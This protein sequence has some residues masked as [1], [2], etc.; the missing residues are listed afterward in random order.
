MQPLPA[1]GLPKDQIVEG[2]VQVRVSSAGLTTL[3]EFAGEIIRTLLGEGVCLPRTTGTFSILGIQTT[4]RACEERNQCGGGRQG[5]RITASVGTTALHAPSA[6][7]LRL[8]AQNVTGHAATTVRAAVN[9]GIFGTLNLSCAVNLQVK[10]LDIEADVNIGTHADTGGI[11]V[12]LADL[13]TIN[14]DVD[15]GGCLVAELA[16]AVINGLATVR[17]KGDKFLKEHELTV[18][19]KSRPS[20]G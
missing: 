9:L 3:N 14:I 13:R 5:C 12:G 8:T 16:G 2:A 1:G 19:E 4:V 7:I 11:S 6:Q 17:A 15:L 20:I 18:D 10:R